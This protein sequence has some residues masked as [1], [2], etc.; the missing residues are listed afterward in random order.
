MISDIG[1]AVDLGATCM[2]TPNVAHLIPYLATEMGGPVYALANLLD[3]FDKQRFSHQIHHVELASDGNAVQ[4]KREHRIRKYRGWNLLGYRYALGLNKRGLTEHDGIQVLH[5]HGLWTHIHNVAYQLSATKG[6]PHLI[7]THGMLST[8]AL[9]FRRWKKTPIARWF[10]D[11]S[12][13]QSSCIHVTSEKERREIRDYGLK[14]PVAVI[15]LPI[16]IPSEFIA[17]ELVKRK[18]GATLNGKRVLLFLGRIHQVKGLE[19][20]ISAWSACDEFHQEW[21]LVIAGPGEVSFTN[22][23]RRLAE[24]NRSDSSITF[25]PELGASS[26]WWL[27]RRA[28]LFVMPSDF[29]NYCL[30]IAEALTSGLPVL[31]TSGTP[32]HSIKDEGAGWWIEPTT[33]ELISTLKLSL[34]MN[35]GQLSLLGEQARAIS[36]RFNS[37]TISENFAMLY[38]WLIEGGQYPDFVDVMN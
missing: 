30:S 21:E 36:S 17:D 20:L 15:P 18:I 2:T 31:T 14:N 16:S 28:E 37:T 11:A 4:L 22:F 19:R 1:I 5:S 9:Q 34:G 35:A 3:S 8:G 27:Y 38:S 6:L 12:L 25:L 26:K 24:K 29:E 13:N 7:S 10:Q 23:L 33:H 32:W